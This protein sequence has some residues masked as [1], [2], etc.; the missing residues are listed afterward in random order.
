M[1]TTSITFRLTEEEK[2]ELMRMATDKDI[3]VSH[4]IR[5]EVRAYTKSSLDATV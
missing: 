2:A 1:K 3:P 5:E 4:I